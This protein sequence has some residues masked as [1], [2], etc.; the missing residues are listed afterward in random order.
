M[1]QFHD[2]PLK[3]PFNFFFAGIKFNSLDVIY[4]YLKNKKTPPMQINKHV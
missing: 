4:L 3:V 1:M 2:M